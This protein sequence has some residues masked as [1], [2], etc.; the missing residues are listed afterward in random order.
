MEREN[1]NGTFL[2]DGNGEFGTVKIAN[3]VYNES[4]I[5]KKALS[6]IIINNKNKI[7]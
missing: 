4:E 5:S 1:E 6:G 3:D 2:L 7:S